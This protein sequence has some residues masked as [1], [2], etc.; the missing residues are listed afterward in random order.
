MLDTCCGLN[1][2]A[3]VSNDPKNRAHTVSTT[4]FA[5][6]AGKTLNAILFNFLPHEN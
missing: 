6:D 5:N 3:K 1:I 2:C 4:P